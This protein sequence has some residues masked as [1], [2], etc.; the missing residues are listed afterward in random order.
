MMTRLTAL[1]LFPCFAWALPEAPKVEAPKAES[2]KVEAPKLEAPKVEAP[3]T[4]G[5]S[6]TQCADG[7]DDDK[8]YVIDCADSDCKADPSC[9]PDGSPEDTDARCSDWLDNDEDGAT[10][11]ED[12]DCNAGHIQACKGSWDLRGSQGARPV[13]AVQASQSQGNLLPKLEKGMSVQDLIG[14]GDDIDG[15]RNDILCSDGIDN[16]LDGATDCEDFGCK[17]DD[18]VTVC[19]GNPGMRFSMVGILMHEY[20]LEEEIS[21]TRFYR[22]QMRSFGPIPRIANSF[23]LVNMLVERTPRLSFALFQVPLGNKGHFVGVNSGAAGLDQIQ[24]ISLHKQLLI[25][26]PGLTSAFGQFNSAAIEFTGPITSD[27]FL[28]YRVFAGGGSGRFDGNIGGRSVT[29]AEYNYP[30]SSGM[31]LQ[32][33]AVG[34]YSRFDT[35]FLYTP[36][37]LTVGIFLGAKY[38]ERDMERFFSQNLHT[39]IRY[40]RLILMFEGFLKQELEF[41]ANQLSYNIQAGF[42]L[43][44]KHIMLAGDFGEF[45]N[46]DMQNPPEFFS[47]E[48]RRQRDIF[49]YRAGIHWYFFRQIGVVSAIYRDRIIREGRG[50]EEDHIREVKLFARYFF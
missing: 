38:D 30:W 40:N 44:P 28:K 21:D 39:A 41:E 8:D 48:L 2:P 29:G 27:S 47:S 43:W 24:A 34:H 25:D 11:C 33:N 7:L 17:F 9:Q 26:R 32:I 12:D 45:I 5:P 23:Y 37:P 10:D 42:L 36:V 15:E 31:Q 19:N 50:R 4:K 1:L 3:K 20:D 6:E 16:D 18:S 14:K 46:G 22:L 13:Q 35:P 49:Q